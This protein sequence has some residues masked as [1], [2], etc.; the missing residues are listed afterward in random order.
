MLLSVPE[1]ARLL[2]LKPSQIYYRL[3]MCQIDG[4]VKVF[5]SWRLDEQ[6]VRKMYERINAK[7]AQFLPS[8]AELVGFDVLLE[9]IRKTSLQADKKSCFARLE[10]GRG[11]VCNK[12]RSHRL[13][14]QRDRVEQRELF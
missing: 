3:T 8:F 10:G 11:M 1:T 7:R 2:E 9:D 4:A 12:S 13:A 5:S 6:T 14:R